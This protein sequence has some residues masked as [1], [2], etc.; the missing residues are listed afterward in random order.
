MAQAEV[1]VEPE[2]MS[3]AE[4]CA[5]TDE[6]P[7]MMN[8]DTQTIEPEV[9]AAQRPSA[10]TASEQEAVELMQDTLNMRS[11]CTESVS[12]LVR[13]ETLAQLAATLKDT[14]DADL[15]AIFQRQQTV[16]DRI[17]QAT[18]TDLPFELAFGAQ[19][20]SMTFAEAQTES[21]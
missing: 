15:K 5:Q 10:L 13:K 9:D 6:K 19:T 2:K 12:Q 20:K 4:N 16:V 14:S 21:L 11:E 17:M 7:L 1:Q 8:A 18:Q 3:L